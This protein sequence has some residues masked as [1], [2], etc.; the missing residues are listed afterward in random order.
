LLRKGVRRQEGGKH[1]CG[2]G[3]SDPGHRPISRD[4]SGTSMQEI[5]SSMNCLGNSA[6]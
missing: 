3:K 5:A 1:E 6:M 2:R 4:G